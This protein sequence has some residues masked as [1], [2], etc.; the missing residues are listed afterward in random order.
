M[1]L[2]GEPALPDLKKCENVLIV[3]DIVAL[4]DGFTMVENLVLKKYG[5]HLNIQFASL[6]ADVE[7]ISQGEYS[8][9]LSRI[10]SPHH[11]NNQLIWI[12][13]PWEEGSETIA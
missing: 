12:E 13:F 5:A 8:D 9:I 11:I 6:F 4:G 7:K 1:K 10:Y 3:D 2:I